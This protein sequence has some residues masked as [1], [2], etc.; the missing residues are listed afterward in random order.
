[1]LDRPGVRRPD[2]KPD[3][4]PGQDGRM[5]LHTQFWPFMTPWEMRRWTRRVNK[6]FGDDLDIASGRFDRLLGLSKDTETSDTAPIESRSVPQAGDPQSA[7]SANHRR[8]RRHR[9]RP[10]QPAAAIEGSGS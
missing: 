6:E 8:R 4:R 9:R 10:R 3:W 7:V 1:M 2:G 5:K